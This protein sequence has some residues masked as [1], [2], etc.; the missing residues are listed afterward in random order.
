MTT[1]LAVDA[2]AVTRPPVTSR[3]LREEIVREYTTG[4]VN[5]VLFSFGVGMMPATRDDVALCCE[6]G[7]R[8]II[9]VFGNV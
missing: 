8:E 5:D 3:K 9:F 1:T 2:R 4:D 6:K 7:V